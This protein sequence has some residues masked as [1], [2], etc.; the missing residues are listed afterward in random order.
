MVLVEV[1]GGDQLEDSI[2]QV[3]KALVVSWR[4]LRVLVGEGAVGYRFEQEARVAI[5]DPYLLLQKLQRLG[6]WFDGSGIQRQRYEPA[7]SWM[8]SQA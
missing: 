6:E 1:L 3:F 5:V 7:F 8:Y 4:D 2:A